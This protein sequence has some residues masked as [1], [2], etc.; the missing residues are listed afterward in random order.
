MTRRI[1]LVDIGAG[2]ILRGVLPSVSKLATY[3]AR[4]IASGGQPPYTYAIVGGA[5]PVGLY[6]DAATG[7]ISGTATAAG[8]AAFTVRATD[9]S[10]AHVERLYSINVIAEPLTLSGDAPN[11]QVGVPYSFNYAASG[12]VPPYVFDIASG[13]LPAGLSIN[14][15]TGALTGTPTNAGSVFWTVRVTDTE[16]ATTIADGAVISYEALALAGDYAAA[17]VGTAYSSD[18]TISGG[19]GTYSNPRVTV[20]ALP[21]GLT[22]SV[23]SGKLRLSG[24][25]TAAA[26]SNFTAAVDS[27]DGQTAAS[28]QSVAVS[29]ALP[30]VTWNPADCGSALTLSGA[31]L[32]VT[33]IGTN[34][35]TNSGCRATAYHDAADLG[36]FYFEALMT[37]GSVSPF[38]MIGVA[39]PAASM[40]AGALGQNS[41]GWSYNEDG[42]KFHTNVSSAYGSSY[43]T[44]DLIGVFVRAGKL[45]FR[46]NGA[47]QGGGN[48]DT[49]TAP[50][51]T[52]LTGNVAPCVGLY[53]S[54][55]NHS[56]T[57]RFKASD[58]TGAIPTGGQAWGA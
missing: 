1:I 21:A 45:W 9:L 17:T 40:A 25:P 29:A 10:G 3:S 58:F 57:G 48:P 23:V 41:D 34:G 4:L 11:G 31:N 32:I 16:G 13:V 19:D 39:T 44:G 15:A 42:T 36:G 53:R 20:G 50:A 7:S 33:K 8:T 12:G 18:L 43:N 37:E 28:A 22:L 5:L 27:G 47:W 52:D 2:L 24:T 26:T 56:F 38:S 14:A 54:S 35:Y 51:F 55:P 30:V 6:L 46:K 49:D